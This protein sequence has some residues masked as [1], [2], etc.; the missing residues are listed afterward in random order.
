[1]PDE[2]LLL[3]ARDCLIIT[4]KIAGPVLLAG[5]VIGLF[6]SIVQSA[7]SLQDQTISTVP[8]LIVMLIA[9]VMLLPWITQRLVEYAGELFQ[10][11]MRL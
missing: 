11:A 6:I 5:V 10:L 9:V 3:L 4:L 8:K 1:M 2:S 7:T